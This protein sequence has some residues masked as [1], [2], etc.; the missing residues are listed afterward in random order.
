[1]IENS[2]SLR[3][4]EE[5]ENL[6]WLDIRSNKIDNL[7]VEKLVYYLSSCKHELV[8]LKAAQST[9]ALP[10]TYDSQSEHLLKKELPNL[11]IT[12]FK[13]TLETK[14]SPSLSYFSP[15]KRQKPSQQTPSTSHASNKRLTVRLQASRHSI[16]KSTTAALFAVDST[17]PAHY[18][19][20]SIVYA[21][22]STEKKTGIGKAGQRLQ[23][24]LS[25]SVQGEN[26]PA[27]RRKESQNW[28][29]S[30]VGIRGLDQSDRP[31]PCDKLKRMRHQR[32][33]SKHQTTDRYD[34]LTDN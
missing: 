29:R 10:P 24:F 3:A 34:Q 7:S 25:C 11:Q 21:K 9:E 26:W 2:N 30:T 1:M 23:N 19:K 32:Q 22:D 12:D 18:R 5:L 17:A 6:T 15:K 31:A 33:L 28:F 13:F 14:P 8:W 16:S 20:A 27:G 4:L